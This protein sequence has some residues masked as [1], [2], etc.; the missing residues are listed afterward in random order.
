MKTSNKLKEMSLSE[1]N[2]VSGGAAKKEPER[3]VIRLTINGEN[4]LLII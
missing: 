2:Q 1:M 4:Y 3:I